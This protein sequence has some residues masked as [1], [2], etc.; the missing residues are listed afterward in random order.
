MHNNVINNG[1]QYCSLEP[2]STDV[3]NP[4]VM[5]IHESIFRNNYAESDA[6]IKMTTNSDLRV[7]NSEFK[8]NYSLG[9]GSVLFADY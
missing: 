5:T 3:D 9:R 1:G 7:I 8:D 4:L 6:I 2:A